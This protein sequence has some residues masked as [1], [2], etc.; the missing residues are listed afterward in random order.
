MKYSTQKL[1][2]SY[3]MLAIYPLFES[4][5]GSF[6]DDSHVKQG[7]VGISIQTRFSNSISP[8]K[9]LLTNPTH[10]REQ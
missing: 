5:G 3:D 4:T 9:Q 1:L 10:L 7:P 8:P 6:Q 2:P